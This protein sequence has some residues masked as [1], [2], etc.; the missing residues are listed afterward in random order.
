MLSGRTALARTVV[1]GVLLATA[2]ALAEVPA[3]AARSGNHPGFGRIVFDLPAGV[4]A[5][6]A[7]DGTHARVQLTGAGVISFGPPPRNVLAMAPVA[8]GADITLGEGV[9]LRQSR[10]GDK[11]VLDLLDTAAGPSKPVAGPRQ[12]ASRRTAILHGPGPDTV[13]RQREAIAASEATV[14]QAPVPPVA[15]IAET[16]APPP[17]VMALIAQPTSPV[18]VPDLPPA[19]RSVTLPFNSNVAAAA[20]RRG[21]AAY[22]VFDERRP[23]DLIAM[24]GDPIFGAAAVTVLPEATVLR[25]PIADGARLRLSPGRDGW[26]VAVVAADVDASALQPISS[27]IDHG[28][29]LLTAEL[30]GH[31]VSVPDPLTGGLIAVGTQTRAGQGIPVERQA[32]QFTLLASWQ[33]IA[34][35]PSA[36]ALSLRPLAAGFVLALDGDRPLALSEATPQGIAETAA[37][38]FS[39]RYDFPALPMDA[40]RRREQSAIAAASAAPAQDR[41][42]LRLAAAQ[43]MLALGLDAEALA[44]L[45]L[46]GVEDARMADD[47]DRIGLSAIAAILA[48]RTADAGG[49]DDVRLD[50]TDEITL[51]RAMRQAMLTEAQPAAA[52]TFASVAQLALAYPTPLRARVLP[53]IAET[54]AQGGEARAAT[55]LTKT[56]LN[57]DS[58]DFAHALL[59][60]AVPDQ[61]AHAL[62]LLDRLAN[63]SDRLRRNRAALRAIELRLATKALT[64]AQAADAMEPEIY[65]WRGDQRELATRLRVAAL[66]GDAGQ[67][68]KALALLRETAQFWP[69]DITVIQTRL[70]ATFKQALADD[71]AHPLP[72]LEL[73]ALAEENA[74]L[75]PAGEAGREVVLR[76]CDRLAMLDLPQRAIPLLAKLIAATPV[77]DTR[78]E[79]GAQLAALQMEAADPPAALA[80]LADTLAIGTM[81][82]DLLERRTLAFARASAAIGQIAQGLAALDALGTLPALQLQADLAESAKDWPAAAAALR[83]L[84]A[85]SV[86]AEGQ[87]DESHGRTLLRFASAA[88]QTGHGD[89]LAL[90]RSH[91]LP[92]LPAGQMTELLRALTASPVQVLSDLPRAAQEARQFSSFNQA[93]K[94]IGAT[95]TP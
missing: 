6:V 71:S 70:A 76:L 56:N 62:E 43:A 73:I 89:W 11:L 31:V 64:P 57:D 80:T 1:A 25:L 48:G 18:V 72:P 52:A 42:P 39:R 79:L 8:G 69:D 85:L 45:T 41:G 95:A 32:P 2:P 7:Q 17:A 90:V 67:P 14:T 10:I 77:G 78:S 81:P 19:V 61:Q 35:V 49:I 59:A 51:W 65:A 9:R 24:Q 75:I 54:M 40:L 13:A 86:P 20:F 38:A 60:A 33:G 68:R 36:D 47:P 5:S 63:G 91:D 37:Q 87:L 21:D 83:H 50:G 74:D 15:A 3:I 44:L 28:R 93:M 16:T 22:V 58:L 66:R 34:V 4:A 94:D 84:V 26:T 82:S 55:V 27:Q 12:A 46:I 53:L 30:P 29:L 88:A 92:R 23:I